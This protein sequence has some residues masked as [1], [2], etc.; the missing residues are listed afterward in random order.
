MK[1]FY[2]YMISRQVFVTRFWT[3]VL[4]NGGPAGVVGVFFPLVFFLVLFFWFV[5]RSLFLVWFFFF[6]FFG[7]GVV[8]VD[9]PRWARRQSRRVGPLVRAHLP[10]SDGAACVPIGI[11]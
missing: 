10:R 3:Y 9:V 6:V 5:G 7:F 11:A 8:T 4:G 1:A 2:L